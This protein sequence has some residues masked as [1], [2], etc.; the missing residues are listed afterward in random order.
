MHRAA[1]KSIEGS[2]HERRILDFPMVDTTPLVTHDT[3]LRPLPT[4]HVHAVPTRAYQN[5]HRRRF[6][7]ID[8]TAAPNR[9]PER[10]AAKETAKQQQS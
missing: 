1:V 10:R 3:R 8:F 7:S 4:D 2:G 9:E 6:A 5:D